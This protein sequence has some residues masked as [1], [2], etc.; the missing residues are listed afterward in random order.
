MVKW[1]QNCKVYSENPNFHIMFLWQ[2]VWL[3]WWPESITT[4]GF[5]GRMPSINLLRW[6]TLFGRSEFWKR[7]SLQRNDEKEIHSK[8]RM[9]KKFPPNKRWKRN[10]L[11][12]NDSLSFWRMKK[13][14]NV[15]LFPC[16]VVLNSE[17]RNPPRKHISN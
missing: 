12:R 7:N 10:S 11:Q 14:N 1:Y 3:K 4:F 17:K 9:K 15:G 5:N 2:N 16:L 8:E 6:E 13:M